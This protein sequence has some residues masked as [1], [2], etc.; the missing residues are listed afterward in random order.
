MRTRKK[1]NFENYIELLKAI[2][3]PLII[4]VIVI[5]YY[6]NIKNLINNSSKVSVG[7]F[8]MEIKKEAKNQG[9]AELGELITNLNGS[10]LRLLLTIA[11]SGNYGLVGRND[12]GYFLSGKSRDWEKLEAYGLVR[13]NGFTMDEIEIFLSKIG[14]V[15][16]TIYYNDRGSY[17]HFK[18]NEFNIKTYNYTIRKDILSIEN[19]IKLESYNISL[20][21]KGSRSIDI[22]IN[23]VIGELKN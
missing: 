4:L 1:S 9:F 10:E 23:T 3:W 12:E 5:L 8:S 22:I 14:A 15:K 11:E 18:D 2:T 6:S 16:E 17:S 13:F 19:R 7:S 21:D 20:T